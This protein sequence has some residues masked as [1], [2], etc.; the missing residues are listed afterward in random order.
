LYD[1]IVSDTHGSGSI[2]ETISGIPMWSIVFYM[3]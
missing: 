3:R 1:G 2:S